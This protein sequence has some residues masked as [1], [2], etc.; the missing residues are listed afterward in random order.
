MPTFASHKPLAPT[1]ELVM[2]WCQMPTCSR[3]MLQPVI[4]PGML[5]SK[6]SGGSRQSSKQ[7]N[8]IR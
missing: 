8:M 4:H 6:S 3:V 7:E 2:P 1:S 5:T